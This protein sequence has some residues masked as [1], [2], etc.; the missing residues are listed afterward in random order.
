MVSKKQTIG[1][2]VQLT[3][4]Y[5]QERGIENPRLDAEVLLCHVMNLERIDLYVRFDQPLEEQELSSYRDLVRRRSSGEPIAYLLGEK[6]FMGHTFKVS[7]AV[8]IPRPD[9]EILVEAAVNRLAEYPEPRFLDI[10]VGSG[11]ILLSVLKAIPYAKGIGVD[12]SPDALLIAK[13]NATTLGVNHRAGFLLGDT[14]APIGDRKV[15]GILSNPP[16][17]PTRDMGTLQKEVKLE[18]KLALDGGLDG[19]NIYRKLLLDG[20]NYLLP[21]GFLM[22]EMGIHQA[23]P[24]TKIALEMGWVELEPPRKDYGGVE[25]VVTFGLA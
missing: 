1:V 16:Y 18:P 17:I 23:E 20:K 10:G 6:E 9:T 14:L 15:Q 8:L 19:L 24:V 5:F 25:R 4:Q 11:A 2:L 21:G 12:L 22:M 3:K 7:P 13:E